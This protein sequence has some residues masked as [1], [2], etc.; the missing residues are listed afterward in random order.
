MENADLQESAVG[1]IEPFVLSNNRRELLTKLVEDSEERVYFTLLQLER[2]IENE[3]KE[4]KINDNDNHTIHQDDV[5]NNND[6]NNEQN[7]D[8]NNDQNA[9]HIQNEKLNILIKDMDD[10]I[11]GINN[12][13]ALK[14]VARI[15][16]VVFRHQIRLITMNKNRSDIGWNALKNVLWLYPKYKKPIKQRLGQSSDEK[17]FESI[18]TDKDIGIDNSLFLLKEKLDTCVKY[19]KSLNQHFEYNAIDF[20]VSDENIECLTPYLITQILNWSSS[21]FIEEKK[22]LKNV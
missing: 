18:I 14:N 3:L 2:E 4:E 1:F 19:K 20:I 8:E 21:I 5:N 15:R 7:V 16:K 11:S 22:K 10:L 13:D 17:Q 6:A 12:N 9:N